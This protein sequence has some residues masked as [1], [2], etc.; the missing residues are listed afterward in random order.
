[1]NEANDGLEMIKKQPF[2]R[3]KKVEFKEV[4]LDDDYVKAKL[5]N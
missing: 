1:M 3:K 5:G 4:T 2:E